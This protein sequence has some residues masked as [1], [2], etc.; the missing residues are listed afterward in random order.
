VI[1]LK[2]HNHLVVHD[3]C[4]EF[5]DEIRMLI[6]EVNHMLDA[7]IFVNSLSAS[8]T[9]DMHLFNDYRHSGAF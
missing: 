8:K 3:K 6:I 2:V 4:K 9:L 7:K 5:V 1:H